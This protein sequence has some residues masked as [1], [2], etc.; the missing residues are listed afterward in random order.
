MKLDP[1][2]DSP[3]MQLK[4]YIRSSQRRC[5]VKEGVLKKLSI[6]MPDDQQLNQKEIPR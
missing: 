1:H 5:S 2:A 3:L 4:H 6:F